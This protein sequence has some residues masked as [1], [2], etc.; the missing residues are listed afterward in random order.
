M[1]DTYEA[2]VKV[3]DL[4]RRTDAIITALAAAQQRAKWEL[5]RDAIIE[6]AE[7]HRQELALLAGTGK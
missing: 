6:Y 5:I 7:N 1:D 3:K 4:P 2:S